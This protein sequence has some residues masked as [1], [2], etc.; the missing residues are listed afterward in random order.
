[1]NTHISSLLGFCHVSPL[2][3]VSLSPQPLESKLPR[4]WHSTPKSSRGVSWNKDLSLNNH[5]SVF[6][7]KKINNNSVTQS[8]I[9]SI[10][11]FYLYKVQKQTQVIHAVRSED[12]SH[13]MRGNYTLGRKVWLS[14][15]LV[16]KNWMFILHTL[17]YTH[18]MRAVQWMFTY[19]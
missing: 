9:Q 10:F 1:M 12:L 2:F 6:R 13:P 3:S 15:F 4:W 11:K 5:N 19:L 8:P 7:P 14:F 17:K 18:F 16:K